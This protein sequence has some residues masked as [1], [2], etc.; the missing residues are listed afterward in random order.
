MTTRAK[1]ALQHP[2]AIIQKKRR[3]NQTEILADEAA[4]EAKKADLVKTYKDKIRKVAHLESRIDNIDDATPRASHTRPNPRPLYRTM[5]LAD[6]NLGQDMDGDESSTKDNFTS[7]ADYVAE[8]NVETEGDTEGD[9]GGDTEVEL[10]SPV[11]KKAKVQKPT[12]REEVSLAR[13]VGAKQGKAM[14]P[15]VDPRVDAHGDGLG[16]SKPSK[17]AKLRLVFSP[18]NMS[19]LLTLDPTTLYYFDIR[20]KAHGQPPMA[21]LISDWAAQVEMI[22]RSSSNLLTL[23]HGSTGAGSKLSEVA[24]L[25]TN[26]GDI[27][28]LVGGLPDELEITGIERDWAIQSPPKGRTRVTSSVSNM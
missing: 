11:K 9:T 16:K 14:E 15:C 7:D 19:S 27:D 13:K 28:L 3:R 5:A 2:G 10:D 18:I 6:V 12:L 8:A 25:E 20:S 26:D 1:N 22:S 24:N 23:T 17:S 4:A 21:S